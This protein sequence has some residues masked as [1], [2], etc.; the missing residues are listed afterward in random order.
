MGA[1][2]RDVT[3][4]ALLA[5]R[6][7][8]SLGLLTDAVLVTLGAAAAA[9]CTGKTMVVEDAAGLITVAL[10]HTTRPPPAMLSPAKGVFA[11]HVQ[12]APTVG[13][14]F[15]VKP[16]GKVSVTVYV[17]VVATPPTLLTVSV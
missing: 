12:P 1:L 9:T 5:T 7:G 4:D 8:D 3:D 15:S 14:A 2:T 16:V 13:A 10:V 6:L 17:P 11:V